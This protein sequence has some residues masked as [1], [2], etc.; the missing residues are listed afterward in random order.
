MR[1]LWFRREYVAPILSGAK[2]I[3]VRRASSRL[4]AAGDLIGASIGP[5][6]PFAALRI[7]RVEPITLDQLDPG[8]A[9]AVRAFYGREATPALRAIHFRLE[10][11]TPQTARHSDS[12][13]PR[14]AAGGRR[15]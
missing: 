5:R 4:P 14:A 7:L 3:T 9:E 6:P 12:P 2:Q 13:R 11:S 10:Q 8:H 15:A 1:A